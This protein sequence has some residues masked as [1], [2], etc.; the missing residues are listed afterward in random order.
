MVEQVDIRKIMGSLTPAGRLGLR[1]GA[2][3]A[4][5]P[6][7]GAQ[8]SPAPG[9][10]RGWSRWP[11]RRYRVWGDGLA[12]TAALSEWPGRRVSWSQQEEV[13][14]NVR[15]VP[16]LDGGRNSKSRR[17]SRAAG[18]VVRG[19]DYRLKPWEPA[20]SDEVIALIT[21]IQRG[22]FSLPSAASDQPDLAD[23]ARFYPARGGEFW[24]A[25]HGES[26]VG[27][28]AAL[29]IG[30]EIAA[31]RKMFVAREHRGASGFAASLM[32]TLVGWA[33]GR[34][35]RTIFLGTTAVME[36]AHRFYERQGFVSIEPRE[37]PASFPRM[38][39]DTRFYRIHLNT[40]RMSDRLGQ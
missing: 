36:A 7:V 2:A 20:D 1:A 12:E 35:I 5:V 22:E 18:S 23:I 6:G 33:E 10:D 31:L 30:E 39:V 16:R 32:Q 38:E 25:R 8:R 21:G 9:R 14:I 24:I 34:G 13:R 11:G 19:I 37:L 26:V 28:I 15:S 40:G 17:S 27:T 4:S 29:R 3:P